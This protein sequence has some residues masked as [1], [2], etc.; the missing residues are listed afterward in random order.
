MKEMEEL[1]A[2]LGELGIEGD[3]GEP[4]AQESRKKK[5]KKDKPKTDADS[6][7]APAPQ[8]VEV[9]QITALSADTA[10]TSLVRMVP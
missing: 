9:E 4:D 5:K 3:K 2:V 8:P 7:P 10:E 6:A 1:K